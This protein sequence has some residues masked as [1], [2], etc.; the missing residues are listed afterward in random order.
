[1]NNAHCPGC[2]RF[3]TKNMTDARTR[4]GKTYR[5]WDCTDPDCGEHG[6]LEEVKK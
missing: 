5:R 4:D 3:M 2:G 1:M 6:F